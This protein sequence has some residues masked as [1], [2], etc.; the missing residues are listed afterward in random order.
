MCLINF[1]VVGTSEKL[2]SVAKIEAEKLIAEKEAQRDLA[3]IEVRL[4]GCCWVS[5]DGVILMPSR[6]NCDRHAIR[7]I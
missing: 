7:M 3:R 6:R 5:N 2:L 4:V 1:F